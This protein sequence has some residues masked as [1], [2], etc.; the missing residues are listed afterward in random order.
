MSITLGISGKRESGKSL[1]ASYLEHY[2]GFVRFSLADELKKMAMKEFK[3]LPVQLWGN[4]KEEPTQYR[5]TDG[6]M[7]T[8]RDILIRMGTF[9]RSIDNLY[10][11]R[12]FD[13]R[14]GDKIVI[15][16]IRFLN[17]VEFFKAEYG[18]KFVRLERH[19][20]LKP[21]KSA[22]DDLSETEMDSYKEFDFKLEA[23]LNRTPDDLHR[24]AGYLDNRLTL[25]F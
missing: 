24:F 22:L 3:L 9:Y 1:L 13:P 15:D 2:Y 19:Q 5:R 8:G 21:H 11:C 12:K 20:E 18:A 25:A 6:S 23:D 4:Q 10:W 7:F 17:E 16:D 14:I